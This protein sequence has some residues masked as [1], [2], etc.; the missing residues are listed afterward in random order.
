MY[1][2]ICMY[3]LTMMY[4][5]N[6][7]LIFLSQKGRKIDPYGLN[8]AKKRIVSFNRFITLIYHMLIFS[9]HC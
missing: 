6:P 7:H 3:A 8:I 1:V 4:I 5:I 9:L 2:C